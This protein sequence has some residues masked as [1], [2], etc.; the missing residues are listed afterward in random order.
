[1]KSHIR[2]TIFFNLLCHK[3]YVKTKAGFFSPAAAVW[4]KIKEKELTFFCLRPL[5]FSGLILQRRTK[6][7]MW[8]NILINVASGTKSH[9]NKYNSVIQVLE[10][11]DSTNSISWNNVLFNQDWIFENFL[12]IGIMFEFFAIAIS[13]WLG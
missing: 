4:R 3:K 9:T 1:M 7:K 12:K 8:A 13:Y 11:L 6:E 2:N 10:L 5:L